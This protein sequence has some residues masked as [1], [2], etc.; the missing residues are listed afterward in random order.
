[1]T[2]AISKESIETAP[3]KSWDEWLKFFDEINAKELPHKD[4]AAKV[5]EH[6]T[7]GWWSQAVTVAYEQYIGRRVPGQDHSGMFAV[8]VSKT[9]EGNLDQALER[10]I[11]IAD[12]QKSFSDVL[13]SE[14]PDISKTEKW[15]YWRC[16]L[17]DGSR[18]TVGIYRKDSGKVGLGLAHEKLTSVDQVE[19]WRAFW[20]DFV[21]KL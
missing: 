13:I 19:G 8:S 2:Q 10:W 1:M 4:I 9:L 6:G 21:N 18:V 20:K 5:H 14:G 12:G 3:G 16:T 17:A 11:H 15:R 7:P